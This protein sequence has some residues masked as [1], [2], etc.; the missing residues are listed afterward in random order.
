MNILI[1]GVNGF[2]G[3]NLVKAILPYYN[4]SKVN[5]YGTYF[6]LDDF[7]M[8][9][10]N[11]TLLPMDITD[12][13]R[14]HKIVESTKPDYVFHLAA[15]SSVALSWEM[16]QL[17]FNINVNGTI[18]LLNAIKNI[19]N[20][21]RILVI[22]TSDEYGSV[23]KNPVTENEPVNPENPYAISKMCQERI[24]QLYVNAYN[25]SIVMTRSF[26]HIGPL[27][28]PN[29]VVADWAKQV[30]EIEKGT[31]EPVISVGNINIKREFTDVRDVIKAYLLL[32]EKGIP[33]EVYN[34]G[35]GKLYKL[36]NIL[37][38]LLFFCNKE[39]KVQVDQQKIRPVESEPAQCNYDKLFNLCGWKP[40]FD[41]DQ[42][43]Q[44]I[45]SYWRSI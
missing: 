9:P 21:C 39:I 26:S 38:A 5:L 33:G 7:K 25:M 20:K 36:Q 34:V 12:S 19:N 6:G 23:K 11:I 10:Y 45:M 8:D 4:T 1:T 2:V 30:S 37:E 31:R 15:Q 17:T 35:S 16:P 22:G 43:L 44:E 29:F 32:I 40:E 18:N 28:E 41:I 3:K 27:Q 42:S 13:D 14:I 24:C